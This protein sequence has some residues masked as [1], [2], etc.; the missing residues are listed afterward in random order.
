MTFAEAVATLESLG[1]RRVVSGWG[2]A[3][4]RKGSQQVTIEQ[5]QHSSQPVGREWALELNAA[6]ICEVMIRD[7]MEYCS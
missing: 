2:W 1:W 6:M 4:Y 3:D 5:E 7:T